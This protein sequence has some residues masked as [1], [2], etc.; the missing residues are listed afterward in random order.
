M[1]GRPGQCG[2]SADWEHRSPNPGS[3]HISFGPDSKA[4]AA[5]GLVG[6]LRPSHCLINCSNQRSNQHYTKRKVSTAGRHC[7][8]RALGCRSGVRSYV[9]R[10][11]VLGE[12]ALKARL[13]QL[14]ATYAGKCYSVKPEPQLERKKTF[15]LAIMFQGFFYFISKSDKMK[16][17]A[18]I[19]FGSANSTE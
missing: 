3:D 4:V 2:V 5:A 10:L 1:Q 16:E 12:A 9:I 15:S 8:I 6:L 13:V 18:E 11:T 19:N 7:C 17:K 14:C